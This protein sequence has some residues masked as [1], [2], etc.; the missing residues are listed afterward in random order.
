[1]S[2]ECKN[3]IDQYIKWIKD[4][5]S[6]RSI[7]EGKSCGIVT[8]F[9]DRHNDHLEIY[10]VKANKGLI[11]TDDGYTISDL[12][13][14][15]MTSNSPKREKIFQSILNGFGVKVGA[16][17]DLYIEANSNNVG[18]KKHYLLQAILAVNDMYTLSQE[19]VFSLFKEDVEIFLKSNDL[20]F[21]KDIKLSGKTGFDHNIDFLIPRSHKKPERLIKTINNP[22]KESIMTAIFAFDDISAVRGQKTKDYVVYNDTLETSISQESISALHN[23]SIKPMPWSKKEE[24]LEEFAFA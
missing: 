22:R 15:G 20:V 4:N 6:I 8:P 2:F 14:T 3:I 11:L 1:M 7:E 18:Q 21:S 17:K 12:E 16:N 23:Y 10:A 13:M 24:C 19:N 5:T 9:M